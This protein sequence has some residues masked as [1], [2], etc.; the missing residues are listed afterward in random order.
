MAAAST[1]I[2]AGTAVGGAVLGNRQAGRAN[3]AI[4][5]GADQQIGLARDIYQD[6]R[7]LNQPFYETGVGANRAAAELLGVTP[8]RGAG[9]SF[10]GGGNTANPNGQNGVPGVYGGQQG[11]QGGFLSGM[12]GRAHNALGASRGAGGSFGGVPNIFSGQHGRG[13]GGFGGFG[14]NALG[15]SLGGQGSAPVVGMNG[16]VPEY[17]LS[18]GSQGGMPQ[19]GMSQGG[20]Q[21]GGVGRASNDAPI[22]QNQQLSSL[23]QSPGYQ[24]RFQE[25][26]NSL[27][28][29]AAARGGLLSGRHVRSATQ[30]GQDYASGEYNNRFNQ[31]QALSGGGQSAASNIQNAGSNYGQ[32]AGNALG[33]SMNSQANLQQQRGSIYG[34]ALGML[35]GGLSSAL[36]RN[37]SGQ[38]N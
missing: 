1:I 28:Q 27:D 37:Q 12:V 38:G 22:Y 8:A 5:E 25:G 11:G 7:Q 13:P 16:G 17:G 29:S 24:F 33:Q 34:G 36:N 18:G 26:L 19:P 9:G 20:L 23:Q 2:A 21:P 31:L 4:Q 15:A 35:G 32:S 10:G 30:Y 3:D 14:Q 6:Q